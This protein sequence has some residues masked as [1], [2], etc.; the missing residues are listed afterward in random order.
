MLNKPENQNSLRLLV[1][2]S[3]YDFS[4]AFE[5]AWRVYKKVYK[6]VYILT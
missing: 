4:V 2:A 1:E 5:V 6:K 3:I